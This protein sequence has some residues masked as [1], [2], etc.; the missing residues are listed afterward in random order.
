MK[1]LTFSIKWKWKKFVRLSMK[2]FA[3]TMRLQILTNGDF[4]VIKAGAG[5]EGDRGRCAV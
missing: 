3:S 5:A 2:E 1:K 4:H